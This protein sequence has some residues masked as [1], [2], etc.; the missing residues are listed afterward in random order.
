MNFLKVTRSMPLWINLRDDP[1]TKNEKT[2]LLKS[3]HK[4]LLDNKHLEKANRV[5]AFEMLIGIIEEPTARD[6]FAAHLNN[7]RDS[8]E[9]TNVIQTN[10]PEFYTAQ[11]LEAVINTVTQKVLQKKH[12]ATS[13]NTSAKQKSCTRYAWKSSCAGRSLSS[14]PFR[15]SARMR[16]PSTKRCKTKTF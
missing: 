10:K 12:T 11:D 16:R 9:I 6:V 4:K 8:Y 2:I 14:L 1:E 13:S 15:Y 3:H 7:E 5:T